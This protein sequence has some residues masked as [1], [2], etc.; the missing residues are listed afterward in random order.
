MP[1]YSVTWVVHLSASACATGLELRGPIVSSRFNTASNSISS[2]QIQQSPKTKATLRIHTTT[3]QPRFQSP[4]ISQ[5]PYEVL[6][7][8]SIRPV[9]YVF[10][11]FIANIIFYIIGNYPTTNKSMYACM[12]YDMMFLCMYKMSSY[13]VRILDTIDGSMGQGFAWGLEFRSQISHKVRDGN[14][15]L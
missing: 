11:L 12:W 2:N 10:C 14:E 13:Q 8:F 7:S 5:V 9:L 4:Q 3:I 15:H 6:H 1:N